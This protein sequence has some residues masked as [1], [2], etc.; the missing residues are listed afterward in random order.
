MGW[1][2]ER[3][4][5]FGDFLGDVVDLAGDVLEGIGDA[6]SGVFKTVEKTVKGILKDPLPTLLQIG[7]AMIGI[8]PY[9]TSAVI[10]AAKGGDLEDIAKSAAISYASTELMSNTQIG[11]DIKNYTSNAFA[12]DFT[13]SMMQNFN[14]PA[15]TAVQIAKVATSSMNSALVGGINAALTGKSIGAGISS[16][17]TSGLVYASTD[18]YFDT[19]NK[20]PNWGFSSQALNLMKGATSTAL[21]TIVSGKGDPAQ[22]LGNYIAYAT[23]NLGGTTLA[24]AAKDAYKLLTTDTDAAK[25][26]Q[27]KY[28]TAKAEYDT[29]V[30]AGEKL[31]NEINADAVAYDKKITD[32]F[33]PFKTSY[34]ALIADNEAAVNA[35]NT[36]KKNY[37]DNK[38]AYNNYDAKLK[39][40]GWEASYDSES[41]STSYFKR[42]GGHY[43]DRSD[44]EGGTYRV[45]VADNQETDYEGNITSTS[46]KYDTNAPTQQSFADK[47]NAA[48]VAAN[49]AAEKAD[50]TG[51]EAQTLYDNN[52]TMLDSLETTKT[53]IDK[54]VADLTVIRKDVEDASVAGS[55]AAALKAASDA[56]QTKYDAWAKTKEAADRSAENY[57]KALAEVATRD[58]T[59][60]ALNTG[61]IS[62]TSKDWNGNWQ[63]SNGMTLTTQGKFIQDGVQQFTNAAGIP[64]KV[65]DFKAADGSNVDFDDNAGRLLS[66]TDVVNICRRDYGFTPTAAEV[67]A[68][69]GGTYN[70]LGN[71]DMTNL[72]NKKARETYFSVVGQDP[73]DAQLAQIRKTGNVVSSAADLAINGLDLPANYVSPGASVDQKISFGQAYAAARSAKGNGAVFEWNGKQ[74]TTENKEEQNKRLDKYLTDAQNRINL[75]PA[76]D[77]AGAGRGFVAGKPAGVENIYYGKKDDN[78]Y[79]DT[80][81]FDAMGNVTGGSLSL[82]DDKT[83]TNIRATNIVSQ[84]IATGAQ[85][86]GELIQS[87]SSGAALASGGN[88]NNAAYNLG[89]ALETWGK[90]RDGADVNQQSKNMESAIESAGKE[91]NIFKQIEI[92]TKAAKDNPLGMISA[93]GKEVVQEGPGWA[94]GA[95]A[96]AGLMAVGGGVAAA[97]LTAAGV[98][99]AMDGI[100]SFGAGGREAYDALKKAGVPED[101]AREKAIVNGAIHAAVTAPAEFLA[102]KTLFKAYLNSVSGGVKEY[103]AK[104]GSTIATNAVSEFIEAVPQNLS[105]QQ[106]TTGKMDIK[107]ATAGALYESMIGGGTATLVLGPAAINDA[108]IVAKDFAG[109]NVSLREFMDGTRDV[110]LSTLDSSATIGTSNNGGTVTLGALTAVGTDIGLSNTELKTFLPSSVTDY[111]SVVYRSADGTAVTLGNID[112][113]V[114]KNPSLDFTT[115]LDSVYTTSAA[116]FKVVFSP[117]VLNGTADLKPATDYE[118][119]AQTAGFPSYAVYQQHGGDIAAYN[120]AQ[121]A[122]LAKAAGFPDYAAYTKYSGDVTAYNTAVT[123][124]ANTKKAADA[125]FPDYASYTKYGGDVDA[126]NT[127]KTAEANTKKATDAGFPDYAAYTQYNGDIKAYNTATTNAANLQ[128]ATAAGFP[129]FASYTKFNGDIKAYN[130]EQTNATNLATAKAAGF[131]DYA[132][133]SLYKGDIN[134]FNTANSN[135]ANLTTAKAAGFPDYAS[136]TQYKGDLGAYNNALATAANV[137][138]ATDAGFP[139]YASYTQYNGN[140][141]AYKADSSA[142]I[143]GWKDATEQ[144]QAK[145]AGYTDPSAYA[146]Y[147]TNTANTQKATTAGFPDYATYTQYNGD[148][149]AYDTAKAASTVTTDS[150]TTAINNAIAGIQFPAGITAADV[151][152]QVKAALAANPTL[153]ATDVT[154]SIAAYMTANPGLT[155]ADVNTAVANA[156]KGLAT[157]DDIATAIA[158]ITLPAGVTMD[159]VVTAIKNFAALNPS[160]S[161]ADVTAAIKTY[162]EANPSLTA[163]D[164]NTAMANATKGLATKADIAT[165]IAGIKLPAGITKEDVSAAIEDYMSKNAGLNAADVTAA[166]K[167]YMDNNP[168]LAAADIK[169]AISDATKDFATKKDIETAI[170]GIKFPTG[171]TAADVSAQITA[172]LKANPGLTAADVTTA[173][174]TYMQ[175]NPGVSA[176]DVSTAVNAA[177]KDLVSTKTFNTAIEGLGLD[178]KTKF[179]SLTQGQ[180]DIVKAYTQQGVDL[181]KAIND[182]AKLTAEQ[183]TSVKTQ[184][185]TL[186]GDVKTKFDALTQGQKDLVNSQIQMGVSINAAIDNAAKQTTEQITNVRT[187]LTRDIKDVQTQFNTRVDELVLQGKTYQEATQEA[188]K[189]LGSGVSGLQTS[190]TDI[191][192]QQDDEA[193]ARK[194]AEDKARTQG[195]LSAAMSLIAPA[196]AA[197]SDDTPY[198][199]IG[200]KTTGEAKFEGPLEQYLKMVREGDYSP[201]PTQQDTQQQNQQVA[202]V[203]DELS[204]QQ[205]QAQQGS[206]YFNYGQQT[207]INDLLGGGKAPEL[208]FKAGGLAT[209]LFAGGGTTRYGH[210]AGGG[211]NVVHHSGKPRLDFRT[212]NAVTGPGDGQS[213]D[214]PAMLADGEFV[215]PADVV[216]A[217][218][219]GSTKAGSDKLYD[220]MHSI[221][222]YHRSAKPKDLPPPAK[223]SPLDYL[224]KPAR[225]ARR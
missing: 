70:A 13:D 120:N 127:A 57:T 4:E 23:I 92:L 8:P 168:G 16:G 176:A 150:V 31:R 208:P 133:Y 136:Y 102:D 182:S 125:G 12:G 188:L 99:A 89:K 189:E 21:N 82:A 220:M 179:D 156:T 153:N 45:Y 212:G 49:A 96:A 206:D 78:V 103:A 41:G 170:S 222:A 27:D 54:K 28:T 62:V 58:A 118:V 52:K 157:K 183:I 147:L 51:K 20:D 185:D 129:D 144:S 217:L 81:T 63:L 80:R 3:L 195:G 73:T 123:N 10:T 163:A 165:A 76:S 26:A 186:S 210:Y 216:A 196:A 174:T 25:L 116:D 84:M 202:Q 104:Y 130:T 7:G 148:K 211:L 214:I 173:I 207:D 15:D 75:M 11:A 79:V 223:K 69:A 67:E 143:A 101:L 46:I 74:Y 2:Q 111:S 112:S 160:L 19:L 110:N 59:I 71:D 43:E 139:D 44:G 197:V 85:G 55:T 122:A 213:D 161:T 66:E 93:M 167:T 87:Y 77:V 131:P 184:L 191:K 33:T 117:S 154:N 17:F 86:F 14:L 64:Q 205:P 39:Q 88:M 34:D 42:S 192:K 177:T 142:K 199:Q 209:P 201:N 159:S 36:E 158:G 164:M 48:A 6:V 193:K 135:A 204:T 108:A 90:D 162:M 224:K 221:R 151:A 29:K 5:D 152:A 178:V 47:A 200:L 169:T 56:Y 72:A 68:I 32:E 24:N 166:V 115:V 106:I 175:N 124:S 22:A 172:A 91:S 61:A 37:D 113:I 97:A 18:S 114:K 215:F 138:K 155:A 198:R 30:T 137:K 194:A 219:N 40:E 146:T 140:V 119:M 83:A 95:V 180:K 50:A 60:D 98:A 35:F 100:E 132:N 38:W 145:T 218:G 94:L 105:T 128:T 187:D 149:A 109:N 171:I 190:V 181:N 1:V 9:V 203:Q 134:A 107:A 141:D 225:T 126:Y 53:A 121:N 65:M